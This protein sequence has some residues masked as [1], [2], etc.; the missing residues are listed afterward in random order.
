MDRSLDGLRGLLDRGLDRLRRGLLSVGLSLVSLRLCLCLSLSGGGSSSSSSGRGGST[1]TLATP[2]GRSRSRLRRG[3]LLLDLRG[4]LIFYLRWLDSSRLRLMLLL[5]SLLLDML[6]LVWLLLLLLLS[7]LCLLGLCLSN[8]LCVLRLGVLLLLLVLLLL[9]L[10][11]GVLRVLL[12][13]VLSMRRVLLLV[14]R[15]LLLLGRVLLRHGQGRLNRA[16]MLLVVLSRG[17]VGATI[18]ERV[19]ATIHVRLD[20]RVCVVLLLTVP[21]WISCE[22]RLVLCLHWH[23]RLRLRRPCWRL[24]L[25]H[26][27]LLH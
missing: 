15:V 12:A 7:R 23:R 18:V 19:V 14:L 20:L 24:L 11:T 6:L 22:R 10:L 25:N 4:R 13:G 26:P 16:R 2:R 8:V 5:E 1:T 17:G 27:P 21:G 3:L 9:G